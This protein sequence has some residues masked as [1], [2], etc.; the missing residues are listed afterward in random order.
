MITTNIMKYLY[1]IIIIIIIIAIIYLIKNRFYD[2]TISY[3]TNSNSNTD[4]KNYVNDVSQFN[5]TKI[6]KIFNITNKKD[7][8]DIIDLAK[9]N[10]KQISIRGTT[11]TMGGHTMN[12]N[13]YI[14]ETLKFN[15]VLYFNPK[16][17]E[18][19]VEPGLIWTDLILY[20]DK[21][22]LS[23][24][25]LQSYSSFSIGGTISVNAHGIT[26]DYGIYKSVL[27]LGLI[28]SENKEIT[29]NRNENKELFSLVIGGYGLFGIISWVKLQLTKNTKLATKY[30]KL[31]IDNFDNKYQQILLDPTINIKLAR[32]NINNMNDISLYT[33]KEIDQL[34]KYKIISNVHQ[35]DPE[36]S[37]ISQLL[38]KWI[39]PSPMCQELR[40]DIENITKAPIDIKGKYERNLILYESA[41]PLAK[42]YSPII[43]INATHI[44]QEFFIPKD[45]FIDFMN[46]LKQVFQIKYKYVTLLNITIRYLYK[47][48]TTFLNYAKTDMYAFVLYYR[49]PSKIV[50]DEE[51]HF[52][53]NMLTEKALE[54][55]GTFYL[56]Y[57]HHYTEK[58]LEQAYPQIKKFFELKEKYDP[59]NL[60]TN[61][62]ITKY[63]K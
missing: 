20:L 38:Y 55:E 62:W 34:D 18:I 24:M 39:L 51:L 29:C 58:Q 31:D 49:L 56:P 27:E 22:G 3:F 4:I 36:M 40:Y 11:H 14:I 32:I 50:A 54:L 35:K 63:N 12:N 10:N 52:I 59:D 17:L 41:T 23:P 30:V 33:F 45:K 44:L 19:T 16:K 37:K 21:Y 1:I 5:K 9:I 46:Y 7:I 47:D 2:I 26:N 53:H 13:G 43:D 28:T 8:H 25:T 61:L 6:N 48:D 57:R 15:K 42:L 60:F